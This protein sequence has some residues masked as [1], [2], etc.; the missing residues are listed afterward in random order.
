MFTVSISRASHLLLICTGGPVFNDF[1]A[2]VDLAAAL[3]RRERWTRILVDCVSVPPT[4]TADELVR[5]G[6]YAGMKLAGTH[7]ALVVSN[8]KRFDGTLSA[9]ASAGGK[10]RYFLSHLDAA[11]WLAEA[12]SMRLLE[13]GS[14]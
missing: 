5:I 10:L 9:A 11:N 6:E 3:C 1:L 8:E 13:G 14:S 4:F 2:L 12:G 7:V